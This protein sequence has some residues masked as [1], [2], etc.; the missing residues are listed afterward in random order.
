M[1]VLRTAISIQLKKSND[2]QNPNSSVRQADYYR[3][4]IDSILD[5]CNAK[6]L[7]ILSVLE[8]ME[9]DPSYEPNFES[10]ED[11]AIDVIN[12]YSFLVAY[13]RGR[14]D[15]QDPNCDILNRK[16]AGEGND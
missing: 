5:I 11:S 16:I 15:G 3:R 2:Y 6:Y 10:I 1:K 9:N 7:R 14:I 13:C 12:Y 8:A 4:G